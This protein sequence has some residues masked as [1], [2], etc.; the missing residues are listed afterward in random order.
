MCD[1]DPSIKESIVDEHDADSFD[2]LP[3]VV[4]NNLR[5]GVESD[6][7]DPFRALRRGE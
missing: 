7:E 1:I 4:K 5:A 3:E 2:D 6:I